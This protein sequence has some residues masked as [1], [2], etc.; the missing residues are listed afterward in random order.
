ME[1]NSVKE[2]IKS[3]LNNPEEIICSA[4]G[5]FHFYTGEMSSKDIINNIIN[6]FD[7]KRLDT[8]KLSNSWWISESI[9][10]L[11]S[12]SIGLYK[13]E[14]TPYRIAIFNKEYI[15]SKRKNNAL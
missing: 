15:D 1:F 12:I 2:M 10:Q 11:N 5:H 13:T 9:P 7:T 14:G 4:K 8:N 3:A 6:T